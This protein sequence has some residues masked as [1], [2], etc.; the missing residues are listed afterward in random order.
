MQ[1]LDLY[2]MLSL[3]SLPSRRALHLPF[4]LVFTDPAGCCW[5]SRSRVKGGEMCMF[6]TCNCLGGLQLFNDHESLRW[7]LKQGGLPAPPK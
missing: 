2:F 1:S 5:G 3:A 4:S 6:Y 7:L